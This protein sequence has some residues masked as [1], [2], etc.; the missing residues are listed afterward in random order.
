MFSIDYPYESS[1][2]A[3]RF[4]ESAAVSEDVRALVGHRN[5]EAI[6]KLT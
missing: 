1:D 3:G 6:L 5:A 4:M 2:I